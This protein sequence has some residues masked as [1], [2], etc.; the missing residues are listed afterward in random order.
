[1]HPRVS[2]RQRSQR[3]QRGRSII[4]DRL[5]RSKKRRSRRSSVPPVKNRG[6]EPPA[7]AVVTPSLAVVH[8]ATASDIPL[9]PQQH[10]NQHR[11]QHENQHRRHQSQHLVTNYITSNDLNEIFD[12]DFGPR[13]HR[14]KESTYLSGDM[15]RQMTAVPHPI[16]Q[17]VQ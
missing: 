15:L 5:Q 11:R 9:N 10:E 6:H 17:L 3:R 12:E 8:K 7:P 13:K 16:D 14:R 2:R 1:M 4:R